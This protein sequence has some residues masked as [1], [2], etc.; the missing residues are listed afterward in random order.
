MKL[1]GFRIGT[2]T[3]LRELFCYTFDWHVTCSQVSPLL[4]LLSI[5]LSVEIYFLFEWSVC[6]VRDEISLDLAKTVRYRSNY[7]SNP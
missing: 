7:S 1:I 5:G 6:C 3:F 4:F 2:I